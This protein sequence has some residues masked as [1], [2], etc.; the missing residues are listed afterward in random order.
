MNQAKTSQAINLTH[1][2]S[3]KIGSK[4]HKAMFM[5]ELAKDAQEMIW[6]NDMHLMRIDD[7]IKL[8]EDAMAAHDA[9]IAEKG[10]PASNDEKKARFVLERT[11]EQK[12]KER[13]PVEDTKTQHTY[14]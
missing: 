4:E 12:K 3:I 7:E 8:T 14:L 6:K 13:A 10:K 11:I 5:D 1:L 2:K 9:K